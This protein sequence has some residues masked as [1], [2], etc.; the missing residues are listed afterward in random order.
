ESRDRREV[1][2]WLWYPATAK[3]P[4]A[5]YLDRLDL[6]APVL[7]RAE[8]AKARSVRIHAVANATPSA[9][10]KLLPVL[11]FSP[12]GGSIP[13]LYTSLWEALAS[14]GFLVAAIDHL[15]DDEAVPLADGRVVKQVE[16]P[17]EGAAMLRFQR[18]RVRVRAQDMQFVLNQLTDLNGGIIDSPF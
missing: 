17:Q 10:P 9:V 14:N 8:V 2:V 18:E 15:Y 13:A 12:G 7:P 6:L 5:P 1:V 3:E 16:P 11:V 4:T